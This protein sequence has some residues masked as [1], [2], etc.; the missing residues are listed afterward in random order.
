MLLHGFFKEQEYG[1]IWAD[2]IQKKHCEEAG[3]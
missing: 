2:R 3:G 1:E